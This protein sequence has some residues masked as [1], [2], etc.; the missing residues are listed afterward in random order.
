MLG[1]LDGCRGPTY[2]FS[3]WWKTL[4]LNRHLH[5][6]QSLAFSL[7][8]IKKAQRWFNRKQT[9]SFS[10]SSPLSFSISTSSAAILSSSFLSWADKNIHS[11]VNQIHKKNIERCPFWNYFAY[12]LLIS[13]GPTNDYYL[14]IKWILGYFFFLSKSLTTT[15]S[16][17]ITNILNENDIV[18]QALITEQRQAT[19]L[20]PTVIINLDEF[21]KK[22][23]AQCTLPLKHWSSFPS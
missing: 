4:N 22:W 23:F 6:K 20:H 3:R 8:W 13:W 9:L 17:K 21:H 2:I 11:L 12:K 7:K 10:F 16:F 14:W 1:L 18:Y 5:F 19:V 15:C